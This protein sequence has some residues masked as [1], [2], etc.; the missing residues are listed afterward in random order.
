MTSRQKGFFESRSFIVLPNTGIQICHAFPLSRSVPLESEKIWRLAQKRSGTFETHRLVSLIAE[1]LAVNRDVEA[2]GWIP[3]DERELAFFRLLRGSGGL[4]LDL[5][6][7]TRRGA[8]TQYQNKIHCLLE[9]GILG[10]RKYSLANFYVE[11]HTNAP[12]VRGTLVVDFGNAALTTLFSPQGRGPAHDRIVELNDPFDINYQARTQSERQIVDSS[13]CFLRLPAE[14]DEEPWVG[15]GQRAGELIQLEPLC[16]YVFAPKKYVRY[17]PEHLKSLEPSTPMRGVVGQKDGMYPMLD[18]VRAGIQNFL[19]CVIGSLVNPKMNSPDPKIYPVIE[20]IILT[21]PLTWRQSDRDVFKELFQ[22]CARKQLHQD[23]ELIDDVDIELICSEPVAVAAYLLWENIYHYG[24]GALRLMNS[25]LGNTAGEP[26]LRILV[27]DIGGGSTDLAVV[28]VSW[29]TAESGDVDV[30]FQMIEAMRFNRAGDRLSHLVV[31]SLLDYLRS[32]YGISE[33][34]DFEAEAR[35]PDFSLQYKRSAVS[36]LNELAES[37]KIHLSQHEEP[38]VLDEDRENALINCFGPAIENK[39][40][41]SGKKTKAAYQLDR[42]TLEAWIR[43]DRQS[44]A[45]SGVPGFMDIF[46]FLRDLRRNLEQRERIP[47]MAVLSGR[48]SRLPLIQ[49][50][51][52]EHLEMPLH[53]VRRLEE[54]IPVSAKH[55]GRQNEDKLSVVL[56]AHRF[57]FGDNIRFIPLPEEQ[58]FNR[59]IG[60]IKE[61]PDGLRLH[62]VFT[63]PGE[64]PPCSVSVEVYPATDVRIGHCFREDGIAEVIAVLS[65]AS[66]QE[67][68]TAVID[69][70]DDFTV[71]LNSGEDIVLTEWVPGGY[72][73]IMDNYNDTG[74][75]DQQPEGLIARQILGEDAT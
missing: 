7:D 35:N 44:P 8:A 60:L 30:K 4:S 56:G 68:R 41:V 28:E 54:L 75:I 31:T 58:I 63:R 70:E 22:E 13:L 14:R 36:K 43:R 29:E 62:Q 69:I 52:A 73:L 1:H 23:K 2:T 65:N 55:N 45:S 72:D 66:K 9:T 61:T 21:Y 39:Q 71:T 20:R 50:L 19:S 33:S 46:L 16:T 67:K 18:A 3:C 59:Y 5:A 26:L 32:K 11:E 24:N 51:A 48:T 17:W 6:I 12:G 10:Y 64:T 42:S 15:M 27:L 49:K 74:K 37:A 57:R 25:T 53:R 40:A 34:L 47:H 38:W